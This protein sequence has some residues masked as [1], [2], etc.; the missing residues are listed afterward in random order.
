MTKFE[1]KRKMSLYRLQKRAIVKQMKNCSEA[2]FIV[3][4][5]Q[6]KALAI[7]FRLRELRAY[8][9]DRYASY[10]WVIFQAMNKPNCTGMDAINLLHKFKYHDS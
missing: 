5:L 6:F 8:G 3:L 1:W 4:G 2:E 7:E 10:A 9:I